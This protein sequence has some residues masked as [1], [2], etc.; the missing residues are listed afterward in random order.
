VR[1][2]DFA[3]VIVLWALVLIALIV[4]HLTAAERTELGIAG[5]GADGAIYQAIFNVLYP[6]Q[7]ER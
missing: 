2:R 1:S 6:R 5:R 7:D 3:H 4:V